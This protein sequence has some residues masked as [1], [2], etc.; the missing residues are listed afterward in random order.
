MNPIHHL[1]CENERLNAVFRIQPL[2]APAEA[3]H[4][5]YAVGVMQFKE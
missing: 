5:R 1:V 2:I 4:F 3:E